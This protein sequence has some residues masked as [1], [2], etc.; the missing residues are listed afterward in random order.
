MKKAAVDKS[1]LTPEASGFVKQVRDVSA[2]HKL[3]KG[4]MGEHLR[5]ARGYGEMLKKSQLDLNNLVQS[6]PRELSMNMM[7]RG[8]TNDSD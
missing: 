7:D 3:I 5:K 8:G 4:K 2:V 6:A 1:K